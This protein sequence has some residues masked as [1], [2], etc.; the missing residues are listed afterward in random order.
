M[1]GLASSLLAGIGVGLTIA[2]PV[3]P[4]SM[5]CVQRTISN[6]LSG[7]LATGLGAATVHFSYGALTIACGA[8]FA[9]FLHGSAYPSILSSL[10]LIW[11]SI[12]ILRGVPVATSEMNKSY[13]LASAYC[14]A[15]GFGLLNP[16]TPAFFAAAM[17]ALIGR[18]PAPV[19]ILASGVFIGSACWWLFLTGSVSAL[20]GRLTPETI[21]IT[22]RFAAFAL[23]MLALMMMARSYTA[24]L[25][26]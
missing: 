3:G 15:V 9:G 10:V 18:G 6:G 24:F 26:T 20:R 21:S 25:Q 8:Q 22:N 4:M 17:P 16:L 19:P 7:G 14:G 11:F 5:L 12:R 23:A 13:N 2:A 1:T